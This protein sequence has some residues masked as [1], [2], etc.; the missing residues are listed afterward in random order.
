MTQELRELAEIVGELKSEGGKSVIL[1]QF[2]GRTCSLCKFVWS[3][4][5]PMVERLDEKIRERVKLLQIDVIVNPRYAIHYKV[6][7]IPTIMMFIVEGGEVQEPILY[8]KPISI[9][10]IKERI[11]E[12]LS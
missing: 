5:N 12:E 10:S 11:I 4:L 7:A 9:P 1:V 6:K 3:Q 2:H 8:E